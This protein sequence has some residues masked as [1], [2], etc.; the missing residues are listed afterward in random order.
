VKDG[1]ERRDMDHNLGSDREKRKQLD[2]V[3][4]LLQVSFLTID[5]VLPSNNMVSPDN[6]CTPQGS[7]RSVQY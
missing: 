2:S 7:V 4:L 6:R 1:T 3:C 5:T